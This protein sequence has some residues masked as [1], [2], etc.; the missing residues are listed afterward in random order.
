M[1]LQTSILV[2][3]DADRAFNHAAA[4]ARVE[5][6]RVLRQLDVDRVSLVLC[7]NKTRAEVEYIQQALGLRH[8]FVTEG[9]GAAFVPAGYFPFDVP[10]GRRIAGYD[11]VEFGRPSLEVIKALHRIAARE[12]ISIAGFSDMSV[13]DVARACDLPLL[14][15][16]LAKLRDYTECF[17]VVEPNGLARRRLWKALEA[18]RLRCSA[19]ERFD[20]VG[21]GTD[22]VLAVAL[23]RALY[24]R[25]RG[26]LITVGVDAPRHAGD[27]DV[28]RWAERIVELVQDT[29]SPLI[30]A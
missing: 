7:S 17:R 3:S 24:T 4:R 10:G 6:A 12:R 22:S 2:F 25:A 9:G 13:D 8:P 14:E 20:Q 19:G 11:A 28:V 18:A 5:A 29:R 26:E 21:A 23:I 15:A 27:G 30:P 1:T 16:R